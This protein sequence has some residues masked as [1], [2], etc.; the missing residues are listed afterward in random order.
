MGSFVGSEDVSLSHSDPLVLELNRLQNLLTGEI[1]ALR[2]IEALKD[3]AVG[4]HKNEV[5]K[6]EEKLRISENLIEYKNLEIKKLA[7]EKKDALAA[8]HAVEATLRR[9]YANQ[10]DNDSVPIELVFP[11]LEAEI[12]MY[13]NEIVALQ[14]D[15]KAM[16]RLTKS[17]ELALLEAEKILRSALDRALMIEEVQNRNYQL[18]RQIEICQVL[19]VEKLSQTIQELEEA[20]LS[21]GAAA[22]SIPDY[23]RWMEE[24]NEEKRTLERQLARIKVLANRVATMVAN[25]WKEENDKV[26]PAE[27]QRLRDK[28]AI[29]KRTAKAEAQLKDK[30]KLRLKITEEGLKDVSNFYVNPNR[31][32]GSSRTEKSSNIFGFLTSNGGTKKKSTSQPRASSISRSLLLQQPN[33]ENET[34]NVAGELKKASSLRRKNS[35]RENLLRK[36]M[37]ASR[38]KVVD[39]SEKENTEIRAD[40]DLNIYKGNKDKTIA[41]PEIKP[42]SCS[43]VDPQNKGNNEDVV[44]GYLYNRLQK[45]VINLSKLCE[46]RDST[47]NAKDEEIKVLMKK[48]DVLTKAIEVE[49]KKQE[50]SSS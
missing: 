48:V 35:S 9:V 28:L 47:L 22:N 2:A 36:G 17:K 39:S 6:T 49:S 8:Q 12:K 41:S 45:E 14:E 23:K 18:K 25:E 50:R 30:L 5:T 27:M 40:I 34:T 44:S 13:K 29:S 46:V 16:E 38:S 15:K 3:K 33:M 20:I 32:C 21:G 43:N 31:F 4:E 7:S 26:M 42:K 11:P 10:K 19:E 24:L 1:K 37:W